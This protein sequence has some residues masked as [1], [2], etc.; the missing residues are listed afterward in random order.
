MCFIFELLHL[1]WRIWVLFQ[2]RG[3]SSYGNFDIDEET[4]YSSVY[5]GPD[6]SGYADEDVLGSLDAE[7]FGDSS[8]PAF[9]RSFA[10]VTSG[11]SGKGF[12][13]RRMFSQ[14][15]KKV[16]ICISYQIHL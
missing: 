5:R 8:G 13:E 11:K 2:E 10:D 16:N 6:D 3:A 9:G 4:K 15:S 1:I 12:E 14:S 7:T